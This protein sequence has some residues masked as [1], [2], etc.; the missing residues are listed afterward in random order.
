MHEGNYL[1]LGWFKVFNEKVALCLPNRRHFQRSTSGTF[2]EGGE[3]C[4]GP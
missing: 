3:V 2:A 1:A 4:H